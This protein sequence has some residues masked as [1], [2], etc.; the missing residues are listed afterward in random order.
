MPP[1]LEGSMV[2]HTYIVSQGSVMYCQF[3]ILLFD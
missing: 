1:R 3:I 2:T